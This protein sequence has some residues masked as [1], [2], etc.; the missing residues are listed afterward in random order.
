M[1]DK[2][3]FVEDLFDFTFSEFITTRLIKV[4]YGIG[5]FFAGIAAIVLI[6]SGFS[7]SAGVGFLFLVFSPIVFF[8]I[9][10][11]FRVYLELIIVLL[12]IAE[13]TRDIASRTE[14][15]K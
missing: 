7:Q 8:F 5:V 4:L 13:Y 12:R 15:L 11:I 2:K 6:V 3:N 9:T 1:D 14:P 10:I